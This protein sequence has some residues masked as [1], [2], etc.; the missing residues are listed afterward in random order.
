MKHIV[1]H[2]YEILVYDVGYNGICM[3][4]SMICVCMHTQMI[5]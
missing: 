5:Y 4:M 1:V 2:V 3:H